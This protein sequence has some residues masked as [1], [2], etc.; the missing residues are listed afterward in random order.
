M[1]QL[2]VNQP[3]VAERDL[4]S[5]RFIP[6]GASPISERTL[7]DAISVW[8]NIMF[9]VYGQSECVP[10]TALSPHHHCPEG[11]EHERG[12]LRSAGRATPNSTVTI[13]DEDGVILLPGEIGEIAIN[14]PGRMKEIWGDA[15]ATA[16]RLLD[17]GSVLSR[18]MGYLDEDGFLFLADRKEDMIISGGFNIWPAEL[19]NALVSHPAV[20]DACV[21]GVAHPKWGETPVG[22]V[23]LREGQRA[24]EQELIAWTSEQVGSVKKVTAVKFVSDLPKTPIGKVLRREVRERHWANAQRRVAGVSPR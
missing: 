1:I 14:S 2:L 11:D 15:E 9:Q 4:S 3:G 21:V 10:A 17:D 24:E 13:R 5:L 20:L 8:G 16:T 7:V 19:E 6:Y 12:W 18:D 22:T 23:V